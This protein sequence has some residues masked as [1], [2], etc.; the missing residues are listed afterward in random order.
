MAREA[1][2]SV[3]AHRPSQGPRIIRTPTVPVTFRPFGPSQPPTLKASPAR[4][5]IIHSCL[6]SPPHQL[7]STGSPYI[8][9]VF[10]HVP[11]VGWAWLDDTPSFIARC[12]LA[13]AVLNVPR[14]TRAAMVLIDSV[15]SRRSRAPMTS[16]PGSFRRRRTRS[17]QVQL[18]RASSSPMSRSALASAVSRRNSPAWCSPSLPSIRSNC[19]LRKASPPKHQS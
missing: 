18:R 11:S 2:T 13:F 17:S 14:C 3:A 5:S 4:T 16:L 12:K 10:I 6:R 1:R 8:L 9:A 7:T 19:S 15:V